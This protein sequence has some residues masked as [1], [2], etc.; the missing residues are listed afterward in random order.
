MHAWVLAGTSAAFLAS[1][2]R[3]PVVELKSAAAQLPAACQQYNVATCTVT[4]NKCAR[5]TQ[6]ACVAVGKLNCCICGVVCL[7]MV[8]ACVHMHNVL[9]VPAH[10]LCSRM[11]YAHTCAHAQALLPKGGSALAYEVVF[12]SIA[13]ACARVHALM[14]MWLLVLLTECA[15]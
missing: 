4:I 3:W 5:C 2:V 14:H 15:C 6:H 10:V 1:C 7:Q 12:F 9:Y 13:W 11:V 8:G